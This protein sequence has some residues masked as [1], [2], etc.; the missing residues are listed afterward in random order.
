MLC[1]VVVQVTT[2]HKV[3]DET[4]LVWCLEGVVE[5]DNERTV[6]DFCKHVLFIESKSF[7]F[8]QFDAFLVKKLH[9]KPEGYMREGERRLE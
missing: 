9:G 5:I 7:A 3:K 8:F 6:I 1:E 4:E 2:I